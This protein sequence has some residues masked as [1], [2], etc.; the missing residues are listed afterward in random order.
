MGFH[1]SAWFG[2]ESSSSPPFSPRCSVKSVTLQHDAKA[3]IFPK[4]ISSL[5]KKEMKEE[6]MGLLLIFVYLLFS[7]L[8]SSFLIVVFS[9]LM[10]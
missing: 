9:H 10:N 6:K 5:T 1:A 2:L 3:H 7:S 8:I 4:P